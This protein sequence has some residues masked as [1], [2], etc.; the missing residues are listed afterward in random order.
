MLLPNHAHWVRSTAG[1][2]ALCL[3]QRKQWRRVVGPSR[4]K[5]VTKCWSPTSLTQQNL[6]ISRPRSW[7]HPRTSRH[8]SS[9]IRHRDMRLRTRSTRRHRVLSGSQGDWHWHL[10]RHM[11]AFIIFSIGILHPKAKAT[12]RIR[13]AHNSKPPHV[14]NRCSAITTALL[15][16]L[17]IRVTVC[18]DARGRD[19]NCEALLKYQKPTRPVEYCSR[20][21]VQGVGPDT[22]FPQNSP[23]PQHPRPR[24]LIH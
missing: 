11:L 4:A 15:S 21:R 7:N 6:W 14:M 1:S 24:G 10:A 22:I 18:S 23:Q 5:N 3:T 13:V 20:L 8:P 2:E 9:T 19:T 12:S 16:L 17:N